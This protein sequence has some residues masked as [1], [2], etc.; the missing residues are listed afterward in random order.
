[1][2]S[3]I[4]I[5]I[6]QTLT[7]PAEPYLRD[8]IGQLITACLVDVVQR[9]PDDPIDYIASW[10]YHYAS[11]RTYYQNKERWAR[12]TE[13]LADQERLIIQTRWKRVLHM[14]DCISKY[15]TVLRMS[16]SIPLTRSFLSLPSDS[17]GFSFRRSGSMSM[18]GDFNSEKCFFVPTLVAEEMSP[19]ASNLSLEQKIVDSVSFDLDDKTLTQSKKLLDHVLP[20]DFNAKD[21]A[22]KRS[23]I[24]DMIIP[25]MSVP[26]HG[27]SFDITTAAVSEYQYKSEYT[28]EKKDAC[29]PT[30]KTRQSKT[31]MGLKRTLFQ[32]IR[33]AKSF[34][35][36]RKNIPSR[37]TEFSDAKWQIN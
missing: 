3:G 15:E 19:S 7:P 23:T 27:T 21:L 17:L 5:A 1:M 9:R 4:G 30:E 12:A 34:R 8:N 25:K 36:T 32:G 26:T 28:K 20:N 33:A 37:L 2:A 24:I 11:T 18:Y 35:D 29:E 13:H 31:W 10:L 6:Q 22:R 14:K 16:P